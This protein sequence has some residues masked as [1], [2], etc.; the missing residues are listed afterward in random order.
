MSRL[1]RKKPMRPS[2]TVGPGGRGC[3]MSC[4]CNRRGT[5]LLACSVAPGTP[6]RQLS[7]Q[8]AS[9]ERARRA[10]PCFPHNLL[11]SQL[12]AKNRPAGMG[13][14]LTSCRDSRPHAAAA[15]APS[16]AGRPI[17]QQDVHRRCHGQHH[18]RRR[19]TSHEDQDER[20]SRHH[21]SK[22]RW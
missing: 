7:C 6:R 9:Q 14:A 20:E 2:S 4:T 16:L 21:F 1:H 15:S 17:V 12:S 22:S 3:D 13:F 18:T 10:A 19:E 11:T 5:G 8:L